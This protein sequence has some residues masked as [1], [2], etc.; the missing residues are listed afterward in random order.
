MKTTTITT[1]TVVTTGADGNNTTTT[2]VDTKTVDTDASKGETLSVFALD[3]SGSMGYMAKDA[4]NGFNNYLENIKG[5]VKYMAL[6]LFNSVTTNVYKVG[7][8]D[9]VLPLDNK[10]YVCSG[11]TAIYDAI[12]NIVERTESYIA[13]NPGQISDVIVTL[14]TDGAENCSKHSTLAETKKLISR[15]EE[16]DNWTFVFL[17]S[18]LSAC[19]DAI[20]MGF[21]ESRTIN[22]VN[23]DMLSVINDLGVRTSTYSVRGDKGKKDFF[24]T[25]IA[26][27]DQSTQYIKY[28]KAVMTG[29]IIPG[30]GSMYVK[31]TDDIK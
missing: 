4:I 26:V 11:G 12:F 14:F 7:L 17:S 19:T 18:D 25:P 5:S 8:T 30:V 9:D 28:D 16:Q 27:V 6:S 20:N 2:S 23:T 29:G 10:S 22:Y 24:D 15:K 1:T 21:G 3:C 31:P 13:L